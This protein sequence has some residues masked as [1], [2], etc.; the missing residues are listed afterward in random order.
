M[1]LSQVMTSEVI[2]ASPDQSLKHAA[3]IVEIMD[4]EA[5]PVCTIFAG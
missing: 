4:F 1:L 3:Q 5:L 2:S